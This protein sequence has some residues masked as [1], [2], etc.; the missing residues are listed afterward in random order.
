MK[1]DSFT[2]APDA[3]V[4]W[5][6]LKDHAEAELGNGKIA[7]VHLAKAAGMTEEPV[8]IKNLK[9]WGAPRNSGF[10]LMPSALEAYRVGEKPFEFKNTNGFM[11]TFDIA[12]GDS[13]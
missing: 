4:D 13:S 7:Q 5:K 6:A 2:V 9:Y 8:V 3:L 1:W 11:I 12:S 10:V